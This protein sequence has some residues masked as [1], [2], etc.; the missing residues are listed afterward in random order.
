L[1]ALVVLNEEVSWGVEL[2]PEARNNW[3]DFEGENKPDE[4]CFLGPASVSW[5]SSVQGAAR[6]DV[7]LTALQGSLGEGM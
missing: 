7:Q 3:S 5:K 1:G 6:R 2:E 4:G